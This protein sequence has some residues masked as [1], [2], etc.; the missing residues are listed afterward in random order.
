MIAVVYFKRY[1]LRCPGSK[2][3][4]GGIVGGSNRELVLLLYSTDSGRHSRDKGRK[5]NEPS[6]AQCRVA[7]QSSLAS[8]GRMW[9]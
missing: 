2:D 3:G 7:R 8:V 1:L 9:P 4:V 6:T 5:G